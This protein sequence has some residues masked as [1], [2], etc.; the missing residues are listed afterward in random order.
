MF[1]AIMFNLLIIF[2]KAVLSDEA[3]SLF[4]LPVVLLRNQKPQNFAGKFKFAYFI[5]PMLSNDKIYFKLYLTISV[6]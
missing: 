5:K 1:I 6:Q 3:G 2:E 4:F